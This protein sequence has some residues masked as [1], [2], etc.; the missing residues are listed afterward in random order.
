MWVFDATNLIIGYDEQIV[1]IKEGYSLGI[2]DSFEVTYT[3]EEPLLVFLLELGVVGWEMLG[4]IV[5]F[6]EVKRNF[7]DRHHYVVDPQFQVR[8]CVDAAVGLVK[9]VDQVVDGLLVHSLQ[10]KLVLLKSNHDFFDVGNFRDD[11]PFDGVIT[12]DMFY[13]FS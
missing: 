11:L 6:F 4:V 9:V 3:V 8:H 2:V 7:V 13:L 12:D 5:L 10:F 1:K